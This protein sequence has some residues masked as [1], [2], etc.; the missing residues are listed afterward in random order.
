MLNRKPFCLVHW[1][2]DLRI[3]GVSQNS[4]VVFFSQSINHASHSFCSPRC[5]NER[6]GN[7]SKENLPT[8]IRANGPPCHSRGRG[9]GTGKKG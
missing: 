7:D 5:M 9:G 2:S 1:M 4:P 8:K 6:F 3:S